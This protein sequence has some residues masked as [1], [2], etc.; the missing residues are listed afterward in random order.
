MIYESHQPN[1]S[2]MLTAYPSLRSYTGDI[3]NFGLAREQYCAKY[4]SK[5]ESLRF[6]V[7]GD[8]VSVGKTQGEIVGRRYVNEYHRSS[9]AVI[10]SP[11]VTRGL[12]GTVLVYKIAGALANTGASLNDVHEVAR[13][14]A[15]RIGTIAVGLEHCHVGTRSATPCKN[16]LSFARRSLVLVLRRATSRETRSRLEWVSKNIVRILL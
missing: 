5:S 1:P 4:P 10:D 8:D 13:F 3:L 12:A 7:V 16:K 11:F 2:C 6:V 14:V 15:D 9:Y